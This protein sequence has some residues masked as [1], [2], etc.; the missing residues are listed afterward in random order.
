MG[1]Y[2]AEYRAPLTEA[3][4]LP[5]EDMITAEEI[6]VAIGSLPRGK[7]SGPDGFLASFYKALAHTLSG[8]LTAVFKDFF[9]QGLITDSISESHLMLLAT[10][11]NDSSAC[12]AYR[13]IFLL[14]TDMTMLTSVLAAR[15]R[16]FIWNRHTRAN[17]ML[18][19]S[20][21]KCLTWRKPSARYIGRI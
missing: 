15:I 11:G 21:I 10:P 14:N 20:L 16:T 6:Q 5:L 8:P 13:P 3:D 12:W 4:C 9:M 18:V 7:D 19:V 2:L 1:S 17:I